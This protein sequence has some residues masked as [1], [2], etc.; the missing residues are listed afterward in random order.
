MVKLMMANNVMICIGKVRSKRLTNCT[1]RSFTTKAL[2]LLLLLDREVVDDDGDDDG[3]DDDGGGGE[4]RDDPPNNVLWLLLLSVFV[5]VLTHCCDCPMSS[6][7]FTM[8]ES[9][10]SF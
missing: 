6:Q 5:F 8:V 7:S 10:F 1:S 2:L 9:S 4:N 3:D